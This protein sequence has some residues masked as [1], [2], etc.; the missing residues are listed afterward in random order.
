MLGLIQSLTLDL[1]ILRKEI[2]FKNSIRRFTPRLSN[3]V[4]KFFS[5]R[6][7]NFLQGV[8]V[9][10][11][12][13]IIYLLKPQVQDI[14]KLQLHQF[15]EFQALSKAIEV[16]LSKLDANDSLKLELFDT[17]ATVTSQ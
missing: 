11:W 5:R 14:H 9:L 4:I 3:N 17:N 12:T 10:I 7:V 8:L 2:A 6:I 13:F 1:D 15:D 16:L